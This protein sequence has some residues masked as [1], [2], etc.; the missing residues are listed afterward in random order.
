MD[1]KQIEELVQ[2]YTAAVELATLLEQD[3]H[4]SKYIEAEM[5]KYTEEG[6]IVMP[7]HRRL[8]LHDD[9]LDRA[10]KWIKRLRWQVRILE[11]FVIVLVIITALIVPTL[12]PPIWERWSAAKEVAEELIQSE[13]DAVAAGIPGA[14]TGE[15]EIPDD[16]ES[17]EYFGR[18]YPQGTAFVKTQ[19]PH[20]QN[21]GHSAIDYSAGN[22]TDILSPI[23][24]VVTAKYV[25][26]YGN[27][28]L[29][30]ENQYYVVTM[31]HMSAI[32]VELGERVNAGQHVAD[33][34]NLGYS[35]CSNGEKPNGRDCGYHIHI[36]VDHQVNGQLNA[37]DY[38]DRYLGGQ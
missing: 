13:A 35:L 5:R 14:R 22:G 21:Y 1:S 27:P 23:N 8:E 25:D 16:I 28:T 11:F 3:E 36:D 7:A 18:I 32:H 19:G 4:L 30:I 31:L 10:Y 34:G 33:E 17:P 29:V 26:E 24:G 9:A 38:L 20:G 37:A 6:K 15:I 2:S 12:D